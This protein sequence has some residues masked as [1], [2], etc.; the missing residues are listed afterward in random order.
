MRAPCHVFTTVCAAVALFAGVSAQELPT[1]ASSP[2]PARF[3]DVPDEHWASDAIVRLMALGVL[4]GYPDGAFRGGE[5][6]TRYELAVVAA[7]LVDLIGGSLANLI[8]D[9]DF[10][11]AVEDAAANV[12]RLRRLEQAT[13]QAASVGYAEHLDDRLAAVEDYLNEQAG[14]DL[15]PGSSAAPSS[16][17]R[18]AADAVARAG[19]GAG[20]GAPGGGFVAGVAELAAG[21]GRGFWLGFSAEYP[22]AATIHLG[23]ADLLPGVGLR[24]GLTLGSGAA[25]GFE[26]VGVFDLP[27]AVFPPRGSLY[28]AG[29]PAGTVGRG[30]SS[31]GVVVLAGLDYRLDP[32]GAG[33]GSLFAEAGPVVGL[34]PGATL[35]AEVRL[36]L[37]YRF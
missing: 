13:G 29:G 34:L 25:L 9:P 5:Y 33:P 11:R 35:G 8:E 17:P 31:A 21:G 1:G 16:V 24:S 10:R 14:E 30:G 6:A 22:F 23:A 32:A 18:S 20:G 27:V 4:T 36:G 3:A 37:N 2:P 28:L 12:E 26:L 19:G 7:R 15:F